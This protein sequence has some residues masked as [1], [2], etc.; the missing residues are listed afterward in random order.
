MTGSGPKNRIKP[1]FEN[2]TKKLRQFQR[3][4]PNHTKL[5]LDDMIAYLSKL[6]LIFKEV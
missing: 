1:H 5:F 4:S 6:H 3:F 2:K